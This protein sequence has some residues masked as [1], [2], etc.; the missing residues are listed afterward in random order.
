LWEAVNALAAR[1]GMINMGQGFPDFEGSRVAREVAAAAIDDGN[2]ASNQYSPQPGL[3]GLREAVAAFAERRYGARYTSS[4]V[5][6]TAGAQEALAAAFLTFLDP[7][8]EVVLF[9]P[10]YPFMLGAVR[11]AGAVPRMVTL[12]PPDFAIDEAA[13]RL[14]CASPK[15]RLLVL[16]SPHNPTG[17]VASPTELGLIAALCQQYDLLAISDEVYEH[18]IF[19]AAEARGVTHRRLADIE[20]MHERTLT[21]GS[22]GKL[23]ALTGWRVAWAC[24]PSQL[25]HPLGASHTH[26][27]FSAPSPLQAGIAAALDREDGLAEVGPLFG[28]NYESLKAALLDGTH[29]R[30]VCHADGGY[31][32]VAQVPAGSSDAE[33]CQV[34][35][36]TKGVVCTPM[37]VFY[38]NAW[39]EDAPCDLIRFTICKSREHVARACAALRQGRRV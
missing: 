15:A 7:G 16:N 13:L 14:A 10:F 24:G 22:G 18:C 33:Y 39:P 12:R 11:Q 31:F 20:G 5:L 36:E 1:P 3:L 27:T 37:S 25:V 9:E 38:A 34:L 30:A 29:V 32:L 35:A 23:F 26:L 21:L 4:E 19:P 17:H 2:A 8:D 6:I 28:S